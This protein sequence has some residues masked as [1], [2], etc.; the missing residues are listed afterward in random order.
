MTDVGL[1]RTATWLR[2]VQLPRLTIL[3]F[4]RCGLLPAKHGS[5]H[6]PALSVYLRQNGLTAELTDVRT[7]RLT[8]WLLAISANTQRK[9]MSRALS[10]WGDAPTLRLSRWSSEGCT[11]CAGKD[12]RWLRSSAY[13]CEQSTAFSSK[14]TLQQAREGS[15][16][17]SDPAA[18]FRTV[19]CWFQTRG[20]KRILG[21]TQSFSISRRDLSGPW[22][23]ACFGTG[24]VAALHRYTY[25]RMQALTKSTATAISVPVTR[26]LGGD[27]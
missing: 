11:L 10:R 7:D 3:S 5:T 20:T 16:I 21:A 24:W 15:A 17:D 25:P 4:A 8:Y 1:G 9:L 13:H 6:I 22:F 27:L 23:N 18:L 12:Q 14:S 19:G 2:N 26:Q